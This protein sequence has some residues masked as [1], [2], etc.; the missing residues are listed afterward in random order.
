MD[1]SAQVLAHMENGVTAAI[2]ICGY[3][4]KPREE[5]LIFLTKGS[6]CISRGKVVVT[7]DGVDEEPSLEGYPAPFQAQ[8]DDFVQGIKDGKILCN[9]GY[10]GAD[11]IRHVESVW[12]NN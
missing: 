4:V 9:D 2:S 11:I 7:K 8:F 10:Y 5:S 3:N 1:G 12:H 6:L